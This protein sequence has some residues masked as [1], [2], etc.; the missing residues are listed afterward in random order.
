[1]VEGAAFTVV[2]AAAFMVVAAAGTAV[3]AAG[4]AVVAAGTAVAAAGKVAAGTV[5]LMGVAGT[6]APRTRDG[7][8]VGMP[9]SACT[10]PTVTATPDMAT[11]TFTPSTQLI[12]ATGTGV[13]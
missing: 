3:A 7:M 6:V 1:M 12:Q 2:A 11:V 9:E 10:P 13:G 4:M 5:A 8:V